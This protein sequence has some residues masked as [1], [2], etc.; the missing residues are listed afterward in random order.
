MQ[1]HIQKLRVTSNYVCNIDTVCPWAR[2]KNIYRLVFQNIKSGK[3]CSWKK[4]DIRRWIQNGTWPFFCQK[5][6][7]KVNKQTSHSTY[8]ECEISYIKERKGPKHLTDKSSFQQ[9]YSGTHRLMIFDTWWSCWYI[10]SGNNV[11]EYEYN[12]IWWKIFV[13]SL[14]N[15]KYK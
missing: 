2:N 6:S 8:W 5:Y 10:H 12:Q 3:S 9:L 7:V 4:L 11:H 1:E 15:H 14:L 13:S